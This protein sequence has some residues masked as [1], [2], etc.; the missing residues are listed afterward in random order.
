MWGI[1]CE[2]K[3]KYDFCLTHWG[4][5]THLCV[6]KLL[7]IGSDN[8]L[9]PG[10]RQAIIWI[11]AGILSI[12]P[13]GTN[14]NEILIAIHTFSFK[15]IYLQMLSGKW[16]PFCPGLNVL[17]L[18]SVMLHA[19]PHHIDRLVQERHNSSALAVELRLSCTNPSINIISPLYTATASSPFY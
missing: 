15:K 2:F 12:G 5:V 18:I 1:F 10:R 19:M 14:F 9:L 13:L 16:R 7:S 3:L 17:T 6:S 8:G 11:I 4:R